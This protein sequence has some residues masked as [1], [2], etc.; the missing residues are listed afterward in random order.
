MRLLVPLFWITSSL[1]SNRNVYHAHVIVL[2]FALYEQDLV[3]TTTS[4]GLLLQVC[5]KLRKYALNFNGAL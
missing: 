1:S 2:H 4:T 3:M 5:H